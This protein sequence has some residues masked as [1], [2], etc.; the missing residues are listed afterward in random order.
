MKFFFKV[1]NISLELFKAKLDRLTITIIFTDYFLFKYV[2]ITSNTPPP[3]ER[4]LSDTVK[5]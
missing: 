1:Y 3:M 2:Q 4:A 5:Q